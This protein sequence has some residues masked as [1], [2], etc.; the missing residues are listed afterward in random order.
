MRF[1]GPKDA[2]AR[3]YA[4]AQVLGNDSRRTPQG[5]DC[6]EPD[7]RRAPPPDGEFGH[8][9]SPHVGGGVP[10]GPADPKVGIGG[11]N[12]VHPRAGDGTA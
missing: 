8:E 2:L 10:D 9:P 11:G 12:R 1:D 5:L 6:P 7:R 3:L 4:L